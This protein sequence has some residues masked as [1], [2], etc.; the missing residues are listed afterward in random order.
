M[1]EVSNLSETVNR[2]LA[3]L[4][5]MQSRGS[6]L[7]PPGIFPSQ[8]YQPHLGIV[9]EDDNVFFTACI[10][11]ILQGIDC[12]FTVQERSVADG[13]I[14]RALAAYPRYR[15]KDG[16]DTYNYWRTRPSGHFPHGRF[17]HRFEHFRIPDDVDD[18]SLVFLTEN[19]PKERVARLREKLK[20]H[21]NLAYRQARNTLPE[22]RELKVYSSFIG[23]NMYIDFDVC[24]LSNLM[25]L[26]LRHFRDDLNEY[27][28]DSLHFICEVVRK[29]QYRDMP[30]RVAPQYSTTVLILYHLLRLL[31][32]LPEE[33]SDIGPIVQEDAGRL[34]GSLPLGMEKLLLENAL[35][36]TGPIPV[37][38]HD[39][40]VTVCGDERFYYF[41]AGML[42][43]F[44]GTV[45]QRLAESPLTHLRYRSCAFNK[46]LLLENLVLRRAAVH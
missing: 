11:H 35:L 32:V 46:A 30:Y 43:A 26:I 21:S 37:P 39:Y 9:R 25:R 33:F 22:Y 44:E 12:L 7:Y 18:T 13:I 34:H 6:E 5:G 45:V 29:G 27:D 10:V 36:G 2:L 23:K 17:M 38:V 19:A 42:T 40:P 20:G 1:M 16:L 31:P 8:R 41:I 14:E 28:R 4:S 15:N 3:E 24:V